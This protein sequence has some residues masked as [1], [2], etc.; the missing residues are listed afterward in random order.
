MDAGSVEI[1]RE[2]G[3]V[4]DRAAAGGSPRDPPDRAGAGFAGRGLRDCERRAA[5]LDGRW[6]DMVERGGSGGSHASAA[7]VRP[8]AGRYGCRTV[9]QRRSWSPLGS[10]AAAI[11]LSKG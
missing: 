5:A 4:G 8:A 6:T 2:F 1:V 11:G 9:P 10:G 3:D 7:D